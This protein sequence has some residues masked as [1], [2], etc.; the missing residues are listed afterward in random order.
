MPPRRKSRRTAGPADDTV[1]VQFVPDPVEISPQAAVE[2][3]TS[4]GVGSEGLS[5]AMVSSIVAAVKTAIQSTNAAQNSSSPTNLVADAVQHNVSSITNTPVEA[6]E[7]SGSEILPSAPLFSSI[8]VPL[9]SRLSA[10][11][12][13]KIWEEE[14]VTFGSLLDT[15]PNPDK[16]ALSITPPT[17]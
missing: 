14:F 13:N 12:K 3:S 5:D 2:A 16:F 11:L 10:G 9:G 6:V 7:S 8:G 15:S 1:D 4:F 17:S